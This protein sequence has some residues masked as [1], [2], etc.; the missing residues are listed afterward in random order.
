MRAQLESL[1]A[2]EPDSKPSGG[3]DSGHSMHELEW[4]RLSVIDVIL[5]QLASLTAA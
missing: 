2:G 5:H 4:K 3:F 1:H